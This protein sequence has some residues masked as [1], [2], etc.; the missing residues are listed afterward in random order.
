MAVTNGS[1]GSGAPQIIFS[2]LVVGLSLAPGLAALVPVVPRDAHGLALA[3][4]SS[5]R[6]F[7]TWHHL[8]F[9]PYH[10]PSVLQHRRRE[11]PFALVASQVGSLIIMNSQQDRGGSS[12]S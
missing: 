9:T 10:T 5:T 8:I 1:L 3:G 12:V 4:K 7:K 11:R 6:L 2:L